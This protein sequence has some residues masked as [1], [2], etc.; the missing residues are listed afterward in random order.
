MSFPA[1]FIDELIARNPIEDVVS[2][3]VSLNT[4]SG[5][6]W[7]CCPFHTEKTPSFSV[8]AEK[9]LYYCFG[10]G[11]GGGVINFIMDIESLDYPDAVR[12][13]ARRAGLTVPEDGSY[14]S[15]AKTKARLH[16]LNR[17]A[18]RMFNANLWEP[19]GAKAVEYLM[20]K[21][22]L[23]KATITRFGLGFAPDSWDATMKALKNQ[24]FSEKELLD[25][26]LVISS[27]NG[28]GAYDRFRNRVMF[29][30]IDVTG[31]VVGFGGRV[32]D[33]STP[34]Y[35]NSPDTLVFNKSKNLYAINL[36]KKTK[37][38]RIILCEG[39]MDAVMLHQA[40][41]D[42]AVASCGTALTDDQARLIAKYADEAVIAY[43]SDEA[44]TKATKKAITILERHELKVKVLRMGDSK[45]P[46]EFI[47]KHGSEAFK[48]LIDRSENHIEY[49]LL[50]LQ[51][52]YDLSLD[53]NKVE[54][55][56]EATKLIA[57]LSNAVSREVYGARAAEA[58]GVSPDSIAVEV[59]RLRKNRRRK[60]KKAEQQQMLTPADTMQPKERSLRYTN[61][62]SARAE[63]GVLQLLMAS[64]ELMANCAAVLLPEHFSSP[65]LGKVYTSFL[66]LFAEG[67][68]LRI[69]AIEGQ[70]TD[71]EMK[72]V[73]SILQSDSIIGDRKRTLSDY[74]DIIKTEYDKRTFS[75]EQSLLELRDS[76]RK[77]KGYE[78]DE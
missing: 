5:R 19:Q 14:V 73:V 65:L 3:Y 50:S 1:S 11:K 63:E 33:D 13:L 26:G 64:P 77:R 2:S 44:G 52:Q 21:R 76:L 51:N 15:T 46:D 67:L 7:G 9:Q 43:D 42:C 69:S 62:R 39:N 36:A 75:G 20:G 17:Q 30:I 70:L 4:K 48:T 59:E 8:S 55:I 27:K 34:K 32:L 74:C 28:K 41:F 54:F 60:E 58:A 71:E 35:L 61:I 24:G 25:A 56:K 23:S 38:R 47:K 10:C 53:D 40:G 68:S 78:D 6:L 18:A 16:E 72:H 37:Q 22:G 12:F 57:S 45:D 66:Q 31:N 49:Q 29:P